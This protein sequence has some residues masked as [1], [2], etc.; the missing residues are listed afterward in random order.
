VNAPRV[1]SADDELV[2]V[3]KPAGWLVHPAG[4]D[5]PDVLAWAR[6]EG[7]GHL[8]PVHRLDLET[9]GVLVLARGPA[10]AEALGQ[11]F[12][13]RE[14]HKAYLALVHGRTQRKGVIR[15]PLRE[16]GRD[17]EAV[18]R[19]RSEERLGGFTLVRVRPETGRHHQ[20]RR[21]LHGIGHP[22]VGDERYPPDRFRPV[23]SFPGRIFL[24]AASLELPDGRTFEAPLPPELQACLDALRAGVRRC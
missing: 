14:V 23:P 4:T 18:T 13:G 8:H 6:D 9:S 16:H 7:L 21:H 11:A 17:Q 15:R 1:L 2:V 5:A 22:V 10:E 12:A 20:V 24:H 19:W 3:D